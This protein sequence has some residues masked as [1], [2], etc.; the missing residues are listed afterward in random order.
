MRGMW[1]IITL[2]LVLAVAVRKWIAA[3]TSF[4]MGVGTAD[5]LLRSIERYAQNRGKYLQALFEYNMSLARP[6][7]ATGMQR[8]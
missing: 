4:D 5:D 3:L 7:Y 2:F 6:E 8:W 1:N